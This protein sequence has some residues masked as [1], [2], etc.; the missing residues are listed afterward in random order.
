MC[1][2]TPVSMVSFGGKE[3]V[4]PGAKVLNEERLYLGEEIQRGIHYQEREIIE[5]EIS[6][7][8]APQRE[9]S[10]KVRK[11]SLPNLFNHFYNWP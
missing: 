3:A 11:H 4:E 6:Y 8:D 7:L 10:S 5:H 2:F 9:H 1:L